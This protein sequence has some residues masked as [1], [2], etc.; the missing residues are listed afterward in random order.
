MCYQACR[1]SLSSPADDHSQSH[2]GHCFLSPNSEKPFT[3]VFSSP[4]IIPAR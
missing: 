2:Q 3:P 1:G 4:C